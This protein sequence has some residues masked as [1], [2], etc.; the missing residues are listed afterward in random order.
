MD[1]YNQMYTLFFIVRLNGVTNEIGLGE[2]WIPRCTF[3]TLPFDEFSSVRSVSFKYLFHLTWESGFMEDWVCA[4]WLV[5]DYIWCHGVPPYL[6]IQAFRFGTALYYGVMWCARCS[7]HTICCVRFCFSKTRVTSGVAWSREKYGLS[8]LWRSCPLFYFNSMWSLDSLQPLPRIYLVSLR[9]ASVEPGSL[10]SLP[11]CPPEDA[12]ADIGRKRLVP[13]IGATNTCYTL[14]RDNHTLINTN[15]ETQMAAHNLIQAAVTEP[16][17]FSFVHCVTHYAM[18]YEQE[19]FFVWMSFIDC[20][21]FSS[22]LI[23]VRQK[24]CGHFVKE[25]LL[26]K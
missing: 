7:V 26:P 14:L 23:I 3:T 1:K 5:H 10:Y 17:H 21:R 4:I 12:T 8:F 6:S 2:R 13:A 9:K 18:N 15:T 24:L 16:Q 22:R 11:L 25:L 19:R 20:H